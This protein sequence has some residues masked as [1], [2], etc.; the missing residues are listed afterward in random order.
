MATKSPNPTGDTQS[1]RESAVKPTKTL[2][3]RFLHRL[4][5]YTGPYSVGYMDIE[6]PARNPRPI[7]TLKR[8]GKPVLRMDTV[9][10][11]IYYPGDLRKEANSKDGLKGMHRVDWMPRPRLATAKGY[12]KFLNIPEMPV[13]GYLACTTLFTKLPAFRNAKLASYWPDTLLQEPGP[14]GERARQNQDGHK[15]PK[16]PVIIFSHGLGGSRLCYS[17]ICGELASFGFIVVAMEHRDGSGART[18]VSLPE[19][20]DPA[21][22][23]SST[24]KIYTNDDTGKDAGGKKVRGRGKKGVNPYYV[25]DYILPKD[26]AQD[27]SPHNPQGVDHVLRSAQIELRQEEIKEA[28]HVISLINNGQGGEVAKMNLRKRGNIGSSSMGLTGIEWEDWT[29]SMFLNTVSVMG[30]SFGGATTVQLCRDD[31]LTWLASGLILDAWGQATPPGGDKPSNSVGKPIIAISSEAFMHWKDNYDR[32]VSFCNEARGSGALCWMLTIAG[33]THLC[34][35]DF[36]VLYPVWMSLFMKSLVSPS[37]AF[38]LTIVASLEFLEATLPPEQT[39]FRTWSNE[40]LLCTRDPVSD[41]DEA[42]KS[43]HAPD[44]KWV[45][46][47]LK[48]PN[49]FSTRMKSIWRKIRRAILYIVRDDL[50]DTEKG[51]SDCTAS[52]EIWMHFSPAES[53]VQAHRGRLLKA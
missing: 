14:E 47:R 44:D 12:A 40:R 20:I 6:V 50:S 53:D 49:E 48:I 46:V 11:G 17:A 18:H 9:L 52:Q 34:M 29:G 30:H 25:V 28:Y 33:S 39:K 51:V 10:L 45:A 5:H 3:E 4:P 36:A 38:Y 24:A 43:D 27:T 31:S 42:L 21:E 37:R 1:L 8:N 2:R 32:V 26:N 7:S 15:R 19:D 35:T 16:F 22:I 23:E 13:T 41:P